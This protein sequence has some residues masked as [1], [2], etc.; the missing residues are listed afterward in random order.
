MQKIIELTQPNPHS[1]VFNSFENVYYQ[2]AFKLSFTKEEFK[3]I[4]DFA[5]TYFMAQPFWLRLISMNTF[6]KQK[7]K[8]DIIQYQ[9][10]I[11]TK[12]GSWEIVDKNEKE[13]VFGES[14]GFM[15]YHFSM[16]LSK[17]TYESIE[18]STAV[19]L[20]SKMGEYYFWIVKQMHTKFV[21][22]SL[23]NVL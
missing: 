4:E 6:S 5:K 15:E 16:R 7:M 21:M 12:I 1:L 19:K 13:I 20:N 3:S 17:D 14:L 10:Q 9:F 2:D 11:G 23:R 18:V 22:F 8:K